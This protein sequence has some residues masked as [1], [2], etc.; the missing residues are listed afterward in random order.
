M[1]KNRL[2]ALKIV[3]IDALE[4]MGI[5]YEM[6]EIPRVGYQ[7]PSTKFLAKGLS[8]VIHHALDYVYVSK[9]HFNDE[10]VS[11]NI[12]NWGSVLRY[13]SPIKDMIKFILESEPMPT[14]VTE[15]SNKIKIRK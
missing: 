12:C 13:K 10:M 8:V 9:L 11:I 7:S 3:I 14:V 4:E 1:E 2:E 6:S 5:E 15:E